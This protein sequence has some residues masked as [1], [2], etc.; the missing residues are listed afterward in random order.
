MYLMKFASPLRRGHSFASIDAAPAPLVHPPCPPSPWLS[1]ARGGAR[2]ARAASSVARPVPASW[3]GLPAAAPSPSASP[4]AF[5]TSSPAAQ[6]PAGLLAPFAVGAP[7]LGHAT[8]TTTSSSFAGLRQQQQLAGK[9]AGRAMPTSADEGGL[10]RG[11]TAVKALAS[12]SVLLRALRVTAP[13]PSQPSR[14]ARDG[15]GGGGACA[16]RPQAT[17]AV[18]ASSTTTYLRPAPL[19][20]AG[21]SRGV[22][23]SRRL[24]ATQ[25]VRPAREAGLQEEN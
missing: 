12:G 10:S 15:R 13:R 7:P 8:T 25:I 6:C 11:H 20:S 19:A 24:T 16:D 2:A 14:S 17:S 22:P 5:R 18:G 4:V 1:L 23:A 21:T 3:L 9:S